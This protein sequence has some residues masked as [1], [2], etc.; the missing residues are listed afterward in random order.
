MNLGI[1]TGKT[2]E[3]HR[4]VADQ[5]YAAYAE[6][7]DLRSLSAVVGEEALTE[8]DRKYLQFADAFEQ[9]FVKQKKDE[10]R[11]IEQTLGLSW[12]LLSMLPETELKRI[13]QEYIEK[14]W[15]KHWK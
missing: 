2:R 13:K 10:D 9:R 12:E 7:R 8:T 11:G 3:D 14:Y 1:G 5:L 6:G 15:K 4:G